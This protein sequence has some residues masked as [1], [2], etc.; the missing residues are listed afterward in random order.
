MTRILRASPE[1][2]IHMSCLARHEALLALLSST[3]IDIDVP[4]ALNIVCVP[5]FGYVQRQIS[6]AKVIKI[7]L[8]SI[9]LTS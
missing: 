9:H 8:N 4:S 1:V 3:H 7:V 2:E 6:P 5:H